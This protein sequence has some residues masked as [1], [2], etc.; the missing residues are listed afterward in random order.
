MDL[1][2]GLPVVLTAPDERVKLRMQL[3]TPLRAGP[4]KTVVRLVA[5]HPVTVT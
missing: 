3:R 4:L 1:G 2:A 5:A